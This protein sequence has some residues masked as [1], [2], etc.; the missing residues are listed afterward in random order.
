MSAALNNDQEDRAE[1]P[2]RRSRA[3]IERRLARA[4]SRSAPL[5]H[6]RLLD[7][8]R[9]LELWI[10][11]M[12]MR[13]PGLL[14]PFLAFAL[15]NT[16]QASSYGF[17]NCI[18]TMEDPGNFKC[19]HRFLDSISSAVGDLPHNT[20]V[21]NASHNSIQ[22]LPY[23]SFLHLPKLQI[24]Q[25]SCNK[26]QSIEG[27]AF[28]NL[29]ALET[30]NLSSNRL[31]NVS[32]DMFRG[33]ACLTYLL[34]NNNQ[35]K[36]IGPD[37]FGPLQ[38]LW[39]LE[40]QFNVLENFDEVLQGLQNL[41]RLEHLDLCNNNLASLKSI[42]RLPESLFTLLLC[43]NS[44]SR[45]DVEESRFLRN[46][47]T[48]DL[49]YNNISNASSFD[50]VR[51]CNLSTLKLM[52]NG[53]DVF[54][55]LNVSDLRAPSLDYSG[56]RLHTF[57]QLQRVCQKLRKY[58]VS[59]N[60]RMQSNS[61]RNL[62]SNVFSDCPPIQL[63]DLSRNRLRTVGC[64]GELFN[65]T[66]PKLQTLTVEHNLL[67]RLRSCHNKI[68]LQELR[69]ISF[70]FNRILLVSS[71]AFD[72]APNLDRLHLNI[73]NI[74]YL[75][76]RALQGLHK[77]RELR[78]DNNLLTD[79]YYLSFDNLNNLRTLN[80]RNNR[81]SVLFPLIFHSL[82]K[83]R[84]LDL[85]GNNIRRF[86]NR[87]LEGLRS[88]SNLYLDGNRIEYIHSN[89]FIAVQSTLRVLD[90]KGNQITYISMQQH[91]AP[92]FSN[93]SK[94]YDL[95]LQAQQPYGLKIIPPKLFQGLTS[96]R[97]LY[98]SEN[99]ILSIS[100]DAFDDLRKLRY[101]TLADSSNG[102]GNLPP[103]IF[104]NLRRLTS[105][106]LEN[107]GIRTLTLEVFGNLSRL[108]FLQ[109]GKN[110]MQTINSS[111][112]EHLTSLRCLDLRKCPLACTCDNIWF[113]EWL[114][115][116]RVQV[117]YLYNYTC[118]SGQNSSYIY[119]F[120]TRVC[121]QDVGKYLFLITFPIL[122][123]HMILPLLYQ[124]TY[125]HLK[126][127]LYILRAWVNN[128]W[129]RDEGK[130]YKFDAFVSYN[131]TDEKWVL[132]HLVPTLEGGEAPVF[133]LC[134]HHRDF[135]PGKYII[136]NI[137]DSIHNSRHTICIISRKYLQSEWC[138]MEIQ[139]AS[140]RLFDELKDV[141]IPIF[142][143]DIPK[144]E[145]SVYHRMRKVM[146]KKTY[147]S[148]P[149]DPEAQKLF[150]AKLRFALKGSHSDE[151]EVTHWFDK[152][153][154]PLLESPSKTEKVDFAPRH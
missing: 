125:W 106:N 72:Y 10:P 5:A 113:Q 66:V 12:Q 92:P 11:L 56:L 99:K 1:R 97:N 93:L 88:L 75:D 16:Q 23:G 150:W 34:L 67:N 133:R 122:V 61:L 32:Q 40:L 51:L 128:R 109:L 102:M 118:N 78:L 60:L 98:L 53:I 139:L 153:G 50:T 108:H 76:R 100:P 134:L 47:K 83:L 65:K 39:K 81:I 21:V 26:I 4:P 124:H 18:Q 96:L 29:M 13:R 89:D 79:L 87:S 14:L 33:L 85:G 43:N 116:D 149:V 101:L 7:Y 42:G 73:N 105:L 138:S 35:L 22:S 30:L 28:E 147:I 19:M 86:T 131:S 143:E 123:L 142:L 80:L 121:Y 140:Y 15:L 55:L 37:T 3:P 64:V 77:L 95:K 114:K 57:S 71:R 111:V 129:R 151:E 27:G 144:K 68:V 135:H 41:T 45:M 63:L 119:S 117:V 6:Q 36:T 20:T 31:I 110:E 25:L 59:L 82:G 48:L 132:E 127:H 154:K 44:L 52:G 120:D 62:S 9:I 152:E 103:G 49:S 112:L 115:N 145:L 90:L 104:K 2:S 54:Q 8:R 46:V 70:R 74:A 130:R 148:W 107:A 24:L 38:N 58:N 146:L 84:I 94:V 137:V 126:Y 141:L 17:R 91:N 69:D 136:D